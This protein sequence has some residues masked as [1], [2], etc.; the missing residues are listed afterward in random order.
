MNTDT[1]PTETT[2]QLGLFRADQ[3]IAQRFEEWKATPGGAQILRRV[4]EVTAG[5]YRD[6]Q[7]WGIKSNQRYIWE[8][9]RRRLD[10]VRARVARHGKSLARERGYFMNDHFTKPALQ[11]VC[12]NHP[13]W[14]VMFEWREPKTVLEE[15]VIVRQRR[16]KPNQRLRVA[17]AGRC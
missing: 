3:T 13:E 5:C 9:V 12:A 10:K 1:A 11:H 17:P 15:K 4:Y 16:V 14:A 2:E 8:S 7:R 6:F